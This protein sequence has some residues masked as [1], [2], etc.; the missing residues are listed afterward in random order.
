MVSAALPISGVV[1]DGLVAAISALTAVDP[2]GSGVTGWLVVGLIGL[3]ANGNDEAIQALLERVRRARATSTDDM[4]LDIDADDTALDI[5]GDET[6]DELA[7]AIEALVADALACEQELDRKST[8]LDSLFEQLPAHVYVKDEDGR[9]VRTT[10]P[11][12]YAEY[13][14]P[15]SYFIGKTDLEIYPKAAA[16]E[17]YED[18]M[19][20]IE[21]GEPILD[22]VEWAPDM[23]EWMVT[24]KVPWRGEDGSIRGLIGIS[25]PITEQKQRELALETLHETTQRLLGV[26][27]IDAAARIVAD[28]APA[29]LDAEATGIYRYD[30]DANRLRPSALSD[31]FDSWAGTDVVEPETESL[32]WQSYVTGTISVVD[33]TE[34]V[35]GGGPFATGSTNGLVVPLGGHGVFVAVFASSAIDVETNRLAETVGATTEAVFDRLETTAELRERDAEIEAQNERLR[36]Q[37]RINETIRG[38]DQSLIAA[39]SRAE[40]ETAVCE[41]LLADDAVAFAWIGAFDAAGETLEPRAWAGDAGSYLDTVALDRSA[42][43]LEPAVETAVDGTLTLVETVAA[44]VQREPWRRAALAA[45]F[46]SVL[47]VPIALDEY[48]Y[49]VLSV[50]ATES[51]VFGDLEATV[52][53]ELGESIANAIASLTTRQALHSDTFVSLR[54]RIEDAGDLL[55]AIAAAGDCT[56]S[57]EGLVPHADGGARLFVRTTDADPSTVETVLDSHNAIA[58]YRVVS[59]DEVDAVFELTVGTETVVS[60]LVR[61]GGRPRSITADADGLDVQIDVPV[62]TDVRSFV[63]MLEA[64]ATVELRGRKEVTRTLNT[65]QGLVEAL[66]EQLTEKQL[67]TLRTAYLSGYFNWP[68]DTTGEELAS[69]LDVSQPTVNRHLRLGEQ[70]IMAR[71]FDP[72]AGPDQ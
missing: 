54:L 55:T 61:H 45:D 13:S 68:R 16:R 22:R 38:I 42:D 53:A 52:L 29:I 6:I 10:T 18:D 14:R 20:V 63:E 19:H 71:L 17:W 39:D 26:E 21:T 33:D 36:R 28:A 43:A 1:S 12:S 4:T 11:Y 15:E 57:Y 62:S 35:T 30:E 40:L 69:I 24:S 50:Y 51:S 59:V 41:Q 2:F 47:A 72:D 56:V 34:D 64:A 5:D 48:E 66:L 9:H 8:L 23:E 70:R 27:S 7:D 37:V 58:S 32:L 31:D 65:T 49:G 46:Q 60:T 25:Q 3:A 67:E 44:N